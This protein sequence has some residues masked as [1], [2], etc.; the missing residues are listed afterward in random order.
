[1]KAIQI[2][3]MMVESGQEWFTNKQLQEMTGLPSNKVTTRLD[4]MRKSKHF[5]LHQR[6][7]CYPFEFKVEL[8]EHSNE[9]WQTD[10]ANCAKW[11]VALFAGAVRGVMG[12]NGLGRV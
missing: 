1:M 3:K 4:T 10:Y 8:A 7:N 5:V 12:F 2:A 9:T 6:G 11:N